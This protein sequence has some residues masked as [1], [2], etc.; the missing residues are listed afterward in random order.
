MKRV[1]AIAK[2]F[3]CLLLATCLKA[4]TATPTVTSFTPAAIQA[5]S[6]PFTLTV[7]GSNFFVGSVFLVWTPPGTT[8][9]LAAIAPNAGATSTVL[10][11]TVPTTAIPTSGT[12]TFVIQN[13]L[14]GPFNS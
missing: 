7:N 1:D 11:F 10:Q 8:T 4:Q 13:Q 3:A 9:P 6:N 14:S 12:A 5:G 2:L